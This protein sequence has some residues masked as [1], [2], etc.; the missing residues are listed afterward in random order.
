MG[1]SAHATA[2][3]QEWL[4]PNPVRQQSPTFLA[5]GTSFMENNFSIDGE[6]GAVVPGDSHEESA[7]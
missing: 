4:L 7:I 6:W 3:W 1:Y 2:R 5:P